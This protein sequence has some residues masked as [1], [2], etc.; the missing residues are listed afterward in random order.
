[1]L[2]WQEVRKLF[3]L[4]SFVKRYFTGAAQ[5]VHELRTRVDASDCDQSI[6]DKVGAAD[7]AVQLAANALIDYYLDLKS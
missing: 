4:V 5:S 7:D 3:R 2:S 6:K 1:M